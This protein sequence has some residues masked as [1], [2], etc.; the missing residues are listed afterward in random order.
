MKKKDKKS[1]KKAKGSE[2]GKDTE[3]LKKMNKLDVMQKIDDLKSIQESNMI[4]GNNEKVM[5]LANQIIELAIR[6]NM[7]YRIKEQE[8]LLQLMAKKEQKKFFATEIEKECLILNEK[9]DIF[10]ESNEIH[11][12]HE[13]IE[14][15]K[16]KYRNNPEFNTLHLVISLLEKDKKTWIKYLSTSQNE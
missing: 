5:K 9:Y 2:E 11:Q 1:A 7:M 12:A 6:Y 10:I 3:Q 4:E 16:E 15:F 8:D 14:N 13:Q